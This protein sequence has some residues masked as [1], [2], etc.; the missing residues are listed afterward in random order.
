MQRG[1]P[2]SSEHV[3][4]GQELAKLLAGRDP[5]LLHETA[6]RDVR[7]RQR[8]DSVVRRWSFM[9]GGY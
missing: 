7:K 6:E 9:N 2:G 4:K 8:L 3:L 1:A 5:K